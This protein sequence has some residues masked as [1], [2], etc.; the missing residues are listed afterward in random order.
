MMTR[1]NISDLVP[2][3]NHHFVKRFVLL[4]MSWRRK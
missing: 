3:V 4:A 1:A 2:R